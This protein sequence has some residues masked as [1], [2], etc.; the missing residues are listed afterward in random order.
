MNSFKIMN[1]LKLKKFVILGVACLFAIA[2]FAGGYNINSY[3]ASSSTVLPISRGGTNANTAAQASSNILGSNFANY[4]GLLPTSKLTGV[5]PIA[6]GG[7]GAN[8]VKNAMYNLTGSP[9]IRVYLTNTIDPKYVKVLQVTVSDT[10]TYNNEIRTQQLQIDGL[11]GVDLLNYKNAQSYILS[12]K[13][14]NKTF[15]FANAISL[16]GLHSDCNPND[17]TLAYWVIEDIPEAD[18]HTKI[19]KIFIKYQHWGMSYH[20]QWLTY[21]DWSTAGI[22]NF[23]PEEIKTTEKPENANPVYPKCASYTAKS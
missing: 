23:T 15:N 19:L 1:F 10:L 12:F 21:R 17:D 16:S 4:S 20:L 7:T 5:V 22:S 2:I 3:A 11:A 13:G 14:I 8:N 18:E 9:G 6:N